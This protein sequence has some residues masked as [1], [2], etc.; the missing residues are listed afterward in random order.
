LISYTNDPF[1]VGL[2]AQKVKDSNGLGAGKEI[3]GN[4]KEKKFNHFN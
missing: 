3:A 4:C 2:E 1:G